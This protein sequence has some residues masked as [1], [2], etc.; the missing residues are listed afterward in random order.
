MS[1]PVN[2]INCTRDGTTRTVPIGQRLVKTVRNS[3]L[4]SPL[5]EIQPLDIFVVKSSNRFFGHNY[6]NP[7]EIYLSTQICCLQ[8]ARYGKGLIWGKAP[9]RVQCCNL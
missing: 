7:S 1:P 6:N 3:T 5:H 2:V 4:D 9:S 8:Q